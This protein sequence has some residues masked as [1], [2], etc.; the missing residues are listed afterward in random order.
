MFGT[1]MASL[2]AAETVGTLQASRIARESMLVA[3]K[4]VVETMLGTLVASRLRGETICDTVETLKI[5]VWYPGS[6]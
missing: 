1:L 5:D 6:P 2:T 3:S 4:A